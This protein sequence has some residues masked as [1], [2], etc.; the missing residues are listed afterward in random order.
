MVLKRILQLERDGDGGG[1]DEHGQSDK[2]TGF[3]ATTMRKLLHVDETNAHTPTNQ[4][5]TAPRLLYRLRLTLTPTL[6][7]L[8][9]N[10]STTQL[11]KRPAADIHH[12]IDPRSPPPRV[13]PDLQAP[14]DRPA[15]LRRFPMR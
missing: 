9:R 12:H 15:S 13:R 8:D 2:T 5:M 10:I 4:R 6:S 3:E 11:R 1:R 7:P 14:E